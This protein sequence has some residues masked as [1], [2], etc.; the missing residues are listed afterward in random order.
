[1]VTRGGCFVGVD[2]SRRVR[3][4][5]KPGTKYMRC[6]RSIRGC[7]EWRIERGRE[8]DGGAGR[9]ERRV[10]EPSLIREMELG[11]EQWLEVRWRRGGKNW[12]RRGSTEKTKMNLEV[13]KS[14][15]TTSR[16]RL[17]GNWQVGSTVP[18]WDFYCTFTLYCRYWY[19][20]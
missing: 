10:R 12:V 5:T 17:P 15:V 13:T 1:M 18:G 6:D 9:Q 3:I 19:C 7:E 16:Q 20:N 2:C 4:R 8:G 11:Q 14:R